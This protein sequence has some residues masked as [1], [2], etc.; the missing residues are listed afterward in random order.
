MVISRGKCHY[1][2]IFR[3]GGGCYKIVFP[4]KGGGRDGQGK[5]AQYNTGTS[6]TIYNQN[7]CSARF[8]SRFSSL[9]IE[10]G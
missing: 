5:M 4:G 7:I 9:K 2:A 6:N 1:I 10:H 3:G 8:M